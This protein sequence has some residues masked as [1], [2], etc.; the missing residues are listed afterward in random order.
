MRAAA[1]LL[2]E[3]NKK[4][5]GEMLHPDY[6]AIKIRAYQMVAIHGAGANGRPLN[7]AVAKRILSDTLAHKPLSTYTAVPERAF[8]AAFTLLRFGV[9]QVE[10]TVRVFSMYDTQP[11]F[12]LASLDTEMPAWAR[13]DGPQG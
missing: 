9:T 11:Y 12:V 3:D 8:T 13:G 4:I 1:V 10:Q 2:H 6:P 7:V 5:G